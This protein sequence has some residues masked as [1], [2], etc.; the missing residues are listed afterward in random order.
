VFPDTHI[1]RKYGSHT[2]DEVTAA[3][4][5]RSLRATE[6]PATL[7]P[8]LALDTALKANGINPGTSADL[9]VATLFAH[10]LK[11]VL[12]SMRNSG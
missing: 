8:L 2:A 5:R 10:R 11:S 1:L 7:L 6:H 9:T 3:T 12:L 4:F